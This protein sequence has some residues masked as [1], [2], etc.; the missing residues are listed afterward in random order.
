MKYLLSFI[1]FLTVA[2]SLVAVGY[3]AYLF[4]LKKT[5][6]HVLSLVPQSA[7]FALYTNDLG[8]TWAQIYQSEWWNLAKKGEVFENFEK[9][10][11]LADEYLRINQNSGLFTARTVAMSAQK[12]S[13]NKLGL[14]FLFDILNMYSIR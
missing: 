14:L 1:V 5:H 7:I 12:I 10:I 11:Q 8:T 3:F 4:Y 13:K 9:S 2:A 6:R